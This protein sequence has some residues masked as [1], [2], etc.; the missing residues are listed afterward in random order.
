MLLARS[1]FLALLGVSRRVQKLLE[2]GGV[3][4][5]HLHEPP[6][7]EGVAVDLEKARHRRSQLPA[8]APQRADLMA[9]P[10]SP[11]A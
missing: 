4:H 1:L 9:E 3:C 7:A 5:L 10:F 2:L 6:V 11:L 8:P